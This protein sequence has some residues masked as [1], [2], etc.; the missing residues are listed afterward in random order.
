MSHATTE[1]EQ[2]R[3]M[4]AAYPTLNAEDTCE[5]AD[6]RHDEPTFALARAFAV[7]IQGRPDPTDEQ[8]AWNL[9]DAAAVIDDFNPTP[10]EWIVTEFELT[11]EAGLEFTTTINGNPY[12]VQTSEWEESHPVSRATWEQWMREAEDEK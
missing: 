1:I 12:V 8:I 10:S 11:D 4:A 5:V 9:E 7:A 6:H 2:C 3:F